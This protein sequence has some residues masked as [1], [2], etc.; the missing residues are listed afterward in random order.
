MKIKLYLTFVVLVLSNV[1]YA[2]TMSDIT[3]GCAPLKVTFT[4]PLGHPTWFW[5]FKDGASSQLQNPSNTYIKPGTYAVEFKETA[6]GPV[7]KTLTIKVYT[8]PTF[9]PTATSPTKG[10]SPLTV[11]LTASGNAPAGVTI[12]SYSWVFGDGNASNTN[13]TSHSY[14]TG[15]FDLSLKINTSS[16][17]CDTTKIYK[18]YVSAS[19]PP[20]VN[21]GTT[22]SPVACQAPLTL[23]FTNTSTSPQNIPLT[24]SWNLHNGPLTT[25]VT[26]P[27]QT[28]SSDG[29]YVATLTVTDTNG[30][31]RSQS[32]N[33]SVG[34]PK[35][36]FTMP[37]TV[38]MNTPLTF[39]NTSSLGISGNYLWTFDAGASIASTGAFQPSI[40]YSTPGIHTI[41]L[42]STSP[43]GLCFHDTTKTIFVDNPTVTFTITP[44]YSCSEPR[45]F[46]FNATASSPIAS[47]IWVFGDT[48]TSIVQNPNHT[49]SIPDSIY[50]KR[51]RT[52]FTNSVIATTASGCI[53]RYS[54]KDTIHLVWARF[55]PDTAQGCAPLLVKFSDSSKSNTPK[56]PLASWDYDFGDGSPHGTVKNPSHTYN[57]PGKYK[58][59]LIATNS[60]GCKDTS[61][62]INIS[63]GN[64]KTAL[65]F[66]ADN[67][68]PCPGDPVTF[69]HST[70]TADT[71]GVTGWNYQ[72]NGEFLSSCFK[73]ENPTM[74]FNDSTGKQTITMTADYNG[75]L[76]T[77]K[78]VDFINVKGPVAHFDYLTTC[79]ASSYIVQ[80]TDKSASATGLSWDFGDGSSAATTGTFTHTYLASDD[81]KVILTATGACAPS[82]DT[83]IVHVKKIKAK[84]SSDTTICI[85]VP[86]LFDATA[87]S[88]VYGNCYRGYTW[89]YGEATQPPY[90][91]SSSTS[92]L[93]FDSSGVQS[94]KLIVTD[95]NGC[96]DS[97]KRFVKV[98]STPAHFSIS[99]SIICTPDTLQFTDLSALLSTQDTT[100]TKWAWN[101]GNGQTD[102]LQNPLHI[103]ASVPPGTNTLTTG[104]TITDKLGCINST[105]IAI[106][107]YKV[108]SA[109]ST[110]PASPKVCLGTPIVFTASDFTT[111]G[112]SLTYNWDYKDGSTDVGNNKSH[113]YASAGSYTVKLYYTEKA[114]GC[115][116]SIIQLVTVQDYPKAGFYTNADT[117]KVL[118]ENQAVTF[119]D[120]SKVGLYSRPLTN[121]WNIDSG[122]KLFS[123]L[124]SMT[125]AFSKG[126]HTVKLTS[127]TSNGCADDTTRSFL[128]IGP[129]G[130][131]TLANNNIC[132]GDTIGFI[133]KDTS[134]VGSYTWDFGDGTNKSNVSPVKHQYNYLPPG[135]P[136]G[137]G[138]AKLIVY[139][140]GGVC[141]VSTSKPINIRYV[142]ADFTRS[143]NDKDT[144]VCLGNAFTITDSSKNADVYSWN[145][146]DGILSSSKVATFNHLYTSIGK[147]DI[148]LAVKNTQYGCV[149]TMVKKVI[150]NTVP[151]VKAVG[152][153]VCRDAQAQLTVSNYNAAYTYSWTDTAGLSNPNKYDPFLK[154]I[155]TKDYYVT[156]TIPSTGCSTKDTATIFV[157][158]PLIPIHLDTS[159]VIGQFVTLPVNNQNGL[160][161]FNWTPTTGL[162]CL[163]CSNPVVQP[164]DDI[165]YSALMSDIL[166][167][168][169][170]TSTFKIHIFPETF[171]KLPTTFTPNGDGVN[172]VIYVEGWGLKDLLTFEIYNRWGE[173]V[174][175]T[176][177]LTEGW[178]GYYNGMLQNND[179][180][181][182]KVS[183]QTFRNTEILYEGH[184]NLM[185]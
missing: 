78:K 31:A 159:I 22:T 55:Q 93:T 70:A 167:C 28:Y 6:G 73:D 98:Y 101:F 89:A 158:Q 99:D 112:S 54:A 175:K 141:G 79:G 82:K 153:S 150:V 118:C 95:I 61:Y 48:K 62:A 42:K 2:Q 145:L 157:V 15:V 5:D 91:S 20:V 172:D 1:L 17:T 180:Y 46:Q 32:I 161:N 33:I 179:I 155:T 7:I 18:N 80:F 128:V 41:T 68:N 147:Y 40:S 124:D 170:A 176:S 164:L 66:T 136:L 64:K 140:Q 182:Y 84:F 72:S 85:G 173:L 122:I 86:Y 13:P 23:K 148:T 52:V 111:Q 12:N 171:V 152:D 120:T 163:S 149:D 47:W 156:A 117:L 116:D 63:V 51:G 50:S 169:T 30:C 115:N 132:K 151:V 143:A 67:L 3:E 27:D 87:S 36:S 39:T 25:G 34:K 57:T 109:I 96:V 4:A 97:V 106:N 133:I 29:A 142:K 131:F 69:T 100:I 60:A 144:T 134:D 56:E 183:A 108:S 174:F 154:G 35:S 162:S 16:A 127:T 94:I 121:Q 105:T 43:S 10:C 45:A 9:K 8:K 88:D 65:D 181:V 185:R 38:C 137:Q 130:D 114:S 123:N 77:V 138:I 81:Y 160:V 129:K 102:T 37:D 11:N 58:V 83:A 24:Y 146:G 76:T 26:P 113:T 71:T 90:T 75:C 107:I 49:F 178:D 110:A 168:F 125:Y 74:V 14:A 53:A 177:E 92:S 103:F 19:T 21:I 44:T 126:S 165:L 139:G 135:P 104:L 119:K 184:I 59:V 166:G